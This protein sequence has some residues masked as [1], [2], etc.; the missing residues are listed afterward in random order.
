MK[1]LI[2]GDKKRVKKPEVKRLDAPIA[3]GMP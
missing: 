1:P 3:F 2:Q